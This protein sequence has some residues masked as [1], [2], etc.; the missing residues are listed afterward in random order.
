M[1]ETCPLRTI[2]NQESITCQTCP[3]NHWRQNN[4]CL[5][6][7][8]H[9]QLFDVYYASVLVDSECKCDEGYYAVSEQELGRFEATYAPV[10][11]LGVDLEATQEQ[12]VLCPLGAQCRQIGTRIESVH[13]QRN[14]ATAVDGSNTMFVACRIGG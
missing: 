5:P 3:E 13:P 10:V 11:M 8:S 12:C 2:S 4:T 6:C 7:W 9:S 14:Y 1:C